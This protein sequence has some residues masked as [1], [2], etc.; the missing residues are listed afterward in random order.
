[1]TEFTKNVNEM[2]KQANEPLNLTEVEDEEKDNNFMVDRW[3]RF[4]LNVSI[5]ITWQLSHR[6][7]WMMEGRV[8]FYAAPSHFMNTEDPLIL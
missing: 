2:T 7:F 5:S 3:S 4:A 8:S 1:M 6:V